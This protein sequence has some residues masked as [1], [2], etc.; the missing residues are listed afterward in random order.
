MP[1]LRMITVECTNPSDPKRNRDTNRQRQLR[2]SP[3]R[4]LHEDTFAP[5][6]GNTGII[7]RTWTISDQCGNEDSRDQLITIVDTT[8]PIVDPL[9]ADDNVECDGTGIAS[10]IQSWLDDHG[11]GDATDTCGNVVWSQDFDP[12]RLR[13]TECGMTG[14]GDCQRSAP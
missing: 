12:N 5:A 13:A 10:Q 2:R 6:C 8:D 1:F 11:G 3:S 9:P 14:Y 7:T 4:S